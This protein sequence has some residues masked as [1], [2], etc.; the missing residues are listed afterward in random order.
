MMIG[1]PKVP[2]VS[3]AVW[4]R[5]SSLSGLPSY[6]SQETGSAP[7]RTS[8]TAAS[9][10]QCKVQADA[11]VSLILTTTTRPDLRFPPS[12][13][14]SGNV[15]RISGTGLLGELGCEASCTMI[16]FSL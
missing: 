12:S 14:S 15:I 4:G 16:S 1:P 2:C 5:Y 6:P 11:P 7:R 9:G 10:R 8:G 13:S 3:M